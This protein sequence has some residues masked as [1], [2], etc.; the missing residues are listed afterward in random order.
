MYGTVDKLVEIYNVRIESNA[1]EGFE[2]ELRCINADK[3][4]LTHLHNPRISELKGVGT[5]EDMTMAEWSENGHD[6]N[7]KDFGA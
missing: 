2:L 3:P 7:S 6:N 5:G 1:I 4:V